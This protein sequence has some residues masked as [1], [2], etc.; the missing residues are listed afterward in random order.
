MKI[1]GGTVI[2][3]A[4]EKL[5]NQGLSQGLSQ[6]LLYGKAQM[7]VEI[8]REDGLGEAAILKR[9]RE[10]AGLSPEEAQ[11][12]LEQYGKQPV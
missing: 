9:L 8:G 2:E 12:Y 11:E 1:M 6:G 3:T 7:I 4:S 10:K 5:I